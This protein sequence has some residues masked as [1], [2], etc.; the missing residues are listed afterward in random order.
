MILKFLFQTRSLKLTLNTSDLQAPQTTPS[1]FYLFYMQRKEGIQI[2]ETSSEK[3]SLY[4]V[5]SQHLQ[6]LV[7]KK[8]FCNSGSGLNFSVMFL[9]KFTS[10][11]SKALKSHICYAII[12][13]KEEKKTHSIIF[14]ENY[15]PLLTY[16]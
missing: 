14:K 1:I 13:L 9:L 4:L 8:N 5:I 11:L 7:S 10:Q 6:K 12:Y 2:Q 16:F 3:Q 15:I